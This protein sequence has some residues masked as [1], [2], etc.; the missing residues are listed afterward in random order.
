[1]FYLLEEGRWEWGAR[2]LYLSLGGGYDAWMFLFN[3]NSYFCFILSFYWVWGCFDKSYRKGGTKFYGWVCRGGGRG[4]WRIWK[5]LWSWRYS[6]RIWAFECFW[7]ESWLC[8]RREKVGYIWE[9]IF[10]ILKLLYFSRWKHAILLT[11]ECAF[12]L[13]HPMNWCFTMEANFVVT[14]LTLYSDDCFFLSFC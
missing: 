1:M 13:Y 14:S 11:S 7:S 6:E 9:I 10:S 5:V 2:Q 4:Q 3:A 12:F 8:S